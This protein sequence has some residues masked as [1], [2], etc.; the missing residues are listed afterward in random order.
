MARELKRGQM[1]F[2]NEFIAE[3]KFVKRKAKNI[4]IKVTIRL[5]RIVKTAITV[6][7]K[8]IKKRTAN[9]RLVHLLQHSEYCH[10]NF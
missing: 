2:L 5:Y 10:K 3:K 4:P 1:F 9:F 8:T 7:Q 6:A